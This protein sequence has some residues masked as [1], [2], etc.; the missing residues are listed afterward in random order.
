M[1]VDIFRNVAK[2]RASSLP[3]VVAHDRNE[4][5]YEKWNPAVSRTKS[6]ERNQIFEEEKK[7]WAWSFLLETISGVRRNELVAL[8]RKWKFDVRRTESIK[9]VINE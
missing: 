2:N 7:L 3:T 8:R 6:R 4:N 9:K 1:F 5:Q